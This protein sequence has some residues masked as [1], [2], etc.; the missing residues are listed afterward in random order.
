[1][2]TNRME[3]EEIWERR[4]EGGVVVLGLTT[5]TEMVI[6]SG[7]KL[8]SEVVLESLMMYPC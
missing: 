5:T 3:N 1:M 2:I 6:N 7:S 4:I 8:P